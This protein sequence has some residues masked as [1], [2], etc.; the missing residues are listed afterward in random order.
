MQI[1]LFLDLSPNLQQ[2][3]GQDHEEVKEGAG[4]RSEIVNG[5]TGHSVLMVKIG[6]KHVWDLRLKHRF[7]KWK[8]NLEQVLADSTYMSPFR[9]SMNGRAIYG[10]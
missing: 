8:I 1:N 4:E 10:K 3:S 5:R 9:T 6:Q 2:P 7:L